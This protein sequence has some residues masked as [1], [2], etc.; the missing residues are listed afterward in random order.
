M[1]ESKGKSAGRQGHGTPSAAKPEVKCVAVV[2]CA[3]AQERCA[4]VHCA[5]AFHRREHHFAGYGPDI[6]YMSMSCGGCPGRRVSRLAAN[7]KN[8][9]GKGAGIEPSEIV[10]H[11]AACVVTDNGHYP[12]CPHLDYIKTILARKGLRVVEGTYVS[13]TAEKRRQSGHY[14]R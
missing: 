6:I 12:P 5:L 7:L 3:V 13:A 4:G 10:V 14:A 2:Q 9:L 11:L 8:M 1:T